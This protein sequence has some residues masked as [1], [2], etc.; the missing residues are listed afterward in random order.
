M[1]NDENALKLQNFKSKP[2]YFSIQICVPNST[3]KYVD[4]KRG[5]NADLKNQHP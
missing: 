1:H 3:K 5:Q 4:L 2:F